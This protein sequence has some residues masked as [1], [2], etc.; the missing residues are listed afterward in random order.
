MIPNLCYSLILEHIVYIT[1]CPRKVAVRQGAVV[2]NI[3]THCKESFVLLRDPPD[4][5]RV[6]LENPSSALEPRVAIHFWRGMI[7]V[8]LSC[9][10]SLAAPGYGY[11]AENKGT[12]SKGTNGTINADR[13]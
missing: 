3:P 1:W 7:D 9:K 13:R 12:N 8:K 2:Q 10:I 4:P 6:A 11:K 5:A